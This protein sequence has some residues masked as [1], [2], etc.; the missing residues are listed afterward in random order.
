MNFTKHQNYREKVRN[1]KLKE[2]ITEGRRGEE[3]RLRNE[4][5]DETLG[6]ELVIEEKDLL[7]HVIDYSILPLEDLNQRIL[8]RRHALL[9]LLPQYPRFSI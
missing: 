3:P 1:V 5:I 8:Y 9:L 4:A 7:L 6:S 2:K